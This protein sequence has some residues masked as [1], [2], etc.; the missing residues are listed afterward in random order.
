MGLSRRLLN[1]MAIRIPYGMKHEFIKAM[2]PATAKA[3]FFHTET[4][5]EFLRDAPHF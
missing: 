1:P 5:I 2:T 4:H 3:L